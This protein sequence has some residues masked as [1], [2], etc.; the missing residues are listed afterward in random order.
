MVSED[1]VIVKPTEAKPLNLEDIVA[2][3][4]AK[5]AEEEQKK[6]EE[7]ADGVSFDGQDE[8]DI[9]QIVENKTF[10]ELGVCSEICGAVAKMGYK[11][12]TK[13][14]TESLPYAL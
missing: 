14:Q 2:K 7:K 3:H 6:E 10:E 1:E 12:P 5:A 8:D 13:I 9:K 4:K 11:H